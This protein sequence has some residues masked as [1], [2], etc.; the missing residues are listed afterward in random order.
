MPNNFLL[1]FSN[2]L[3]EN[4]HR[5]NAPLALDGL[6]MPAPICTRPP[7]HATVILLAEIQQ[8]LSSDATKNPHLI[9]NDE[10]HCASSTSSSPLCG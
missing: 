10:T 1:L 9:S 2:F 3:F 7:N 5:K 8:W 6:L 4:Q